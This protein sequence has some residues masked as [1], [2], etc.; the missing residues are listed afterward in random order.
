MCKKKNHFAEKC[1]MKRSLEKLKSHFARYGCPCIVVS[2]NGPQFI[3]TSFANFSKEWDFEHRTTSPYNSRANG[4]AESAVKTA[5]SLLRKNKEQDQFLALLNYRNTPTQATG[6]SPVQRFFNRRTRTL[7]PT[8]QNLLKPLINIE[9]ERMKLHDQQKKQAR[10]YNKN[11][12]DLSPLEE[13]DIV[14][15][16][17]FQIGEK[18]WAKDLVKNRLDE[19]SYEVAVGDAIYSRN[20]VHLKKTSEPPPSEPSCMEPTGITNSNNSKGLPVTHE[21]VI[22]PTV[23]SPCKPSS[24]AKIGCTRSGR[25]VKTPA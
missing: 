14:R 24:P 7:L 11:A 20:R 12:K 9:N 17:P 8:S 10:L 13:G 19:R 1:P 21:T 22:S 2:D 5:K 6:T 25:V 16:K 3:S 4:K 23:K 18:K 15:L